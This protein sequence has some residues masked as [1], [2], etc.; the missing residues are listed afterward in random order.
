M[1]IGQCPHLIFQKTVIALWMYPLWAEFFR[2]MD[3]QSPLSVLV[4]PRRALV[5]IIVSWLFA[6][7]SRP[8]RAGVV[9]CGTGST[10]RT[11]THRCTHI[12]VRTIETISAQ[13]CLMSNFLNATNLHST[14][15][16]MFS[17]LT[18][19][20]GPKYAS[21]LASPPALGKIPTRKRRCPVISCRISVAND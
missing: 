1:S 9:R 11:A 16:N 14:A 19:L 10:I 18:P 4:S 12:P 7:T 5:G 20:A 21:A 17:A 2:R 8:E 15:N 13:T 6:W 3:N